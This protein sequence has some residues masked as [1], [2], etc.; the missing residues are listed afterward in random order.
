MLISINEGKGG[1]IVTKPRMRKYQRMVERRWLWRST[2]EP[3]DDPVVELPKSWI[4]LGSSN[5]YRRG[6]SE[7][8]IVGLPC[9]N[10]GR[11]KQIEGCSKKNGV[12]SRHHGSQ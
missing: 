3:N 2:A 7:R 12:H 1:N 5:P 4:F 10:K 6:E 11:G 8:S 9:I